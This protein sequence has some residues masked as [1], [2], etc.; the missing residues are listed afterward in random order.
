M[1]AFS[2]TAKGLGRRLGL[3]TSCQLRVTR[4]LCPG[5]TS[6]SRQD[7]VSSCSSKGRR[8]SREEPAEEAGPDEERRVT[9]I[10]I[11]RKPST[12][13]ERPEDNKYG[14]RRGKNVFKVPNEI[15]VFGRAGR[16]GEE[17]EGSVVKRR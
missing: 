3:V 8:L 10:R 11:P 17:R 2:S 6:A 16:G 12:G 14:G 1:G 7:E 13:K 15:V 4:E 5:K 9:A